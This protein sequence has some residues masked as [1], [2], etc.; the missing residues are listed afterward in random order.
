MRRA[1]TMAELLIVIGIIVIVLGLAVP[2]F[3]SITGTRSLD[4]AQNQIGAIV[5]RARMEAI[6][7]QQPRGV[8]FYLDSV[9][10]RYVAVLVRKMEFAPFVASNGSY[11]AGDYA[12]NA[13]G[14]QYFV[15]LSTVPIT[16]G[17]TGPGANWALTDEYAIDIN[18]DTDAMPL[19]VGVGMQFVNDSKILPPTDRYLS[20]G[21]IMFDSGGRLARQ[22]V[23]IAADGLIGQKMKLPSGQNYPA[24][25]PATYILE[26]QFG[27]VLFDRDEFKGQSWWETCGENDFAVPYPGLPMLAGYLP[28]EGAEEA[29]IDQ[30]ALPILI[31]RY[32]GSLIRGE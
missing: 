20:C 26:S 16:S 25:P 32:S 19:P 11:I 2:A 10:E 21:A 14:T 18:P 4:A 15:C 22:R 12:T 27:F 24:P 23:S 9:N 13:A 6:G 7:L 30:N 17:P 1:F 31:N 28:D 5:A 29:W 8:F 3:N